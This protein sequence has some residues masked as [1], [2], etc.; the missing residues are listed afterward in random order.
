MVRDSFGNLWVSSTKTG[1]VFLVELGEARV[2]PVFTGLRNPHGLAF[3][4]ADPFLLYI[5]EETAISRVRLYSDSAREIVA[6]LPAG[7]RHVTRTIGFGPDGRLYVSIGST[8]DVCDEKNPEHGSIVAM[9][10]DGD[11]RTIVARGLRNTVFF[12]WNPID[13]SLWGADMGR[14][15]LGDDLPPDEVNRIEEGKHYGWPL[16]YGKNVHDAVYDTRVYVKNPCAEWASPSAID[17][18]AHSAPLGV[19]FVPEEGWPED[20]RYDLLVAYHG[21]WNRS[22]PTGYRIVRHRFDAAGRYLGE[23]DFMTGFRERGELR[24]RP[25]GL[26]AEPGGVLFVSDDHAG[27]IYRVFYEGEPPAEARDDIRVVFPREGERVRSPLIVSGEAR[28]PW[29]FEA[30]FSARLLGPRGEELSVAILTAEGEWMTTDFVPFSGTLSFDAPRGGEGT[31]VF[32]AAN[33]SG[34]PEH[35]KSLALPV[36]F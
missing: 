14:D 1:T 22:V 34:L 16:C 21:S 19:A 36:R 17:I 33:P 2:V 7:G 24:G 5:A 31:L 35:A 30:S 9:T 29:F 6:T 11:E 10:R 8:C 25:A 27:A 12:A 18:P 4:P 15:F 26:L 13:G 23:E 20:F 3:D 32:E 28:G